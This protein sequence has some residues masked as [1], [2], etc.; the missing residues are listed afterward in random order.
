MIQIT[1]LQVQYDKLEYL[2]ELCN[3]LNLFSHEMP[4]G[5]IYSDIHIHSIAFLHTLHPVL[6]SLFDHLKEMDSHLG[7]VKHFSLPIIHIFCCA[8]RFL[9]LFL[10]L[11]SR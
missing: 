4:S 5:M 6:Q 11:Y 2:L 1:E 10:F 7:M 8:I 3:Y 9:F